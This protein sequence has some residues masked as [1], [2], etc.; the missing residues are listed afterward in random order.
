[1][2][3]KQQ[4]EENK[5][6]QQF[7]KEHGINVRID[8][9]WGPWQQSQYDKIVASQPNKAN[10]IV[11]SI[12]ASALAGST[13]MEGLSGAGSISLP[14][15]NAPAA[16]GATVAA[17]LVVGAYETLT[18]QYPRIE[19]TPEQRQNRVYATDATTVTRPITVGGYAYVPK[20]RILQL[21]PR[22][23]ALLA[24]GNKKGKKGKKQSSVPATTASPTVTA[25][26]VVP[27]PQNDPQDEQENEEQQNTEQQNNQPQNNQQQPPT[28]YPNTEQPSTQPKIKSRSNWKNWWET[29]NNSTASNFARRARNVGRALAYTEGA[30]RGFDVVG[31]IIGATREPDNQKHQWKWLVSDY[32]SPT[33]F[34]GKLG[35][36]I[37]KLVGDAYTTQDTIPTQKTDTSPGDSAEETIDLDDYVRVNVDSMNQEFR[38]E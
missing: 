27:Q 11:L 26:P 3:T 24:K 33:K 13:I 4:I 12:P 6:K 29:Q 15:I 23:A 20:E 8:G 30:A 5:R 37:Y 1:M 28:E 31:N 25:A 9:S 35:K 17:P 18:G 32:G 10:A 21:D 36:G 19:V 14:A 16:V 38:F 7:L 34:V 22:S 2:P